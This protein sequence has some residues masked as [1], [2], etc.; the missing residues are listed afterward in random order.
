MTE[1]T[2]T[3]KRLYGAGNFLD[4]NGCRFHYARMGKGP[5][6][7]LVH[8][9]PEFWLTWR[10]NLPVLSNMF[11][12]I[13]PDLRG[14]GESR[15]LDRPSD[16]PL[17]PQQISDDLAAFMDALSIEQ[18]GFVSHDIGAQGVQA[19]ARDHP[20]RV[21]AMY[22][23]NCPHPGI[24]RRWAGADSLPETWYQYFNQLPLAVELAG[25]NRDTCRL[26]IGHIL[27]HWSHAPDAFDADLDHWVDNFMRP[28]ALEGGFAWYKGVD[29]ARRDLVRHGPPAALQAFPH[30]T[31]VLWGEFDPVLPVEWMDTL[32]ELFSNLDADICPGAGHF[33]HYEAP[34]TVNAD[35]IGFFR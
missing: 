25:Y 11:D 10:H 17:A 2:D 23:F 6:L 18:A 24:G 5:P 33:V 12:V 3:L 14:F 20:D 7:I 34:K 19:F 1:T 30:R 21:T 29:A 15:S 32:V 31:R 13:A 9:W 8:G 26:Y 4:A 35:I 22:F 16:A 28:G 27:A